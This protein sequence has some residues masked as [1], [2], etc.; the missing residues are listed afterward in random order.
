MHLLTRDSLR[1]LHVDDDNDFAELSSRSL[2]QAGFKQ[3]VARCR[4]GRVALHYFSAIDPLSAPHVILLDFHMPGMNGLE[5]LHWI[6]LNYVE[7][8][9]AVYLLTS[10][11]DPEHKK[12]AAADGA[13][14][15]LAKSYLADQLIEELDTL[16]SLSNR[17]RETNPSPD[18]DAED[19]RATEDGQLFAQADRIRS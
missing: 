2:Q 14:G 1:I 15:F 13:M 17:Q 18:A 9:V 10:S 4:D 11:L 8:N 6:R 19:I 3:P 12:Q 5:V 7:K 16:I